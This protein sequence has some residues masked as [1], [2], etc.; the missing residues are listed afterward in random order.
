VIQLP[1]PDADQ[2]PPTHPEGD[3]VIETNSE[4]SPDETSVLVGSIE[5]LVQ[6]GGAPA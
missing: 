3:P 6:T 4:P 1:F 2:L 5:K